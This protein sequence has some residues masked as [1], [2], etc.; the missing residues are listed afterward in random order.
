MPE[1]GVI[2][3]PLAPEHAGMTFPAYRH[4]LDLR[5][6]C[7]HTDRTDLE[8]IQPLAIGA[9]E[10]GILAGLALAE[11]PLPTGTRSDSEL[12]SLF[13]RSAHRRSGIGTAL[14]EGLEHEVR[15]RGHRRVTAVWMSPSPGAEA[16]E[17]IF[18]KRRWA[19]PTVRMVTVKFTVDDLKKVPWL[20]R[21]R[22]RDGCEISPWAEVTPEEK[23]ALRRSQEETGWIARDL[24]PWDYDREGF[25]PITSLAMRLHGSIVGWT[26][27]HV[28]SLSTV[29][30]TCSFIRKDLGRRGRILPLYT[31]SLKRLHLTRYSQCTFTAPRYHP[32]MARFARK[33]CGPYASY[34][35]ETRGSEKVLFETD[36]LPLPAVARREPAE[37]T[38]GEDRDI[39]G[40]STSSR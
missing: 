19:E 29:R 13:V 27:N 11:L 10:D 26:I 31:E 36:E 20:D 24:Q 5:P 15:D 38:G 28:V 25:E 34:V 40:S 8:P 14:V 39:C 33:H 16:V 6:A 21:Y 7:R 32:T 37:P 4:L 17:R 1:I 22:L 23:E 30:F 2:G 9:W 35:G 18:S 12:L 3:S